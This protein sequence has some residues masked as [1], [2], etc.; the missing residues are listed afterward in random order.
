VAAGDFGRASLS[1]DAR[2]AVGGPVGV[3]L[4]LAGGSIIG[5][6][7]GKSAGEIIDPTEEAALPDHLADRLR[8]GRIMEARCMEN[9][10][11]PG[12]CRFLNSATTPS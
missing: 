11:D 12:L 5:G 6:Y 1:L 9:Y 4:A 8:T 7:V 3:A 10:S 2:A